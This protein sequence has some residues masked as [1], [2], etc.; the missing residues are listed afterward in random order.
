M[1]KTIIIIPCYNEENRFSRELFNDF[2]LKSEACFCFVNDGS[3]DNTLQMLK[4]LQQGRTERI[5]VLDLKRNGGKAEAVRQGI[6]Q[7]V[8]W[9]RFDFIGYFDADFATPL[10]EINYL[11]HQFDNKANCQVVFG[12][13]VKLMGRNIERRILRHYLG[14]IFSTTASLM[15]KLPIYD[16]QC[17]AKIFRLQLVQQIFIQPFISSWLF[18]VEIF[19]RIINL[20]GY[21]QAATVMYEAPLN[22]WLE[23]GGSNLSFKHYFIAPYELLRIKLKYLSERNIEGPTK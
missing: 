19:A 22:Q 7:S 10:S 1:S 3:K 5:I 6:L 20:Y 12:S 9:K 11:L 8:N 21:E 23:I 15:L 17:G 2:Y 18:D 14:R 13:R 4:E 16:T